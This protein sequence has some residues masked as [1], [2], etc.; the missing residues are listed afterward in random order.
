[1]LKQKSV[2]CLFFWN[3]TKYTTANFISVCAAIIEKIR[4]ILS[5]HS[6]PRNLFLI[7]F[8][9]ILNMIADFI[10]YSMIFNEYFKSSKYILKVFYTF[11]YMSL[12]DKYESDKNTKIGIQHRV[13]VFW[14]V[15][16]TNNYK[17]N[18][19]LQFFYLRIKCLIFCFIKN[20]LKLGKAWQYVKRI[21]KAHESFQ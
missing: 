7:L 4:F 15:L 1:M 17:W 16:K 19:I 11:L 8:R 18:L 14:I 2:C 13:K 12:C 9:T 10:D 21:L 5:A 20:K 6:F 3:Y